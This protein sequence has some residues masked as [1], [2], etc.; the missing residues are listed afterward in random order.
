[1]EDGDENAIE[2]PPNYNELSVN[3]D[4]PLNSVSQSRGAPQIVPPIPIVSLGYS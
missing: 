2:A 3:G 4:N 1:M